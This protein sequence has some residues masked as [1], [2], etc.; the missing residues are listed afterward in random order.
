MSCGH[1]RGPL[2]CGA[3]CCEVAK[4]VALATEPF[5]RLCELDWTV[6]THFLHNLCN[7][8]KL[9]KQTTQISLKILALDLLSSN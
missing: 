7:Q 4:L 3:D 1:E 5:Y 2:R 6:W 8:I 9:K